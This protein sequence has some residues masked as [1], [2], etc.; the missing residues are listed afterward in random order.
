M[1][2]VPTFILPALILASDSPAGRARGG[3]YG[4]DAVVPSAPGGAA[5]N[6]G[7]IR[8]RSG[9]VGQRP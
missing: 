2:N 8:A 7:S 4:P 9:A 6:Q 5:R 1:K 3:G